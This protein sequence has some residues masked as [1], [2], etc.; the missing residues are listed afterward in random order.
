MFLELYDLAKEINRTLKFG[1]CEFI[2][3]LHENS[4]I[5]VQ[6]LH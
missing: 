3:S 6:I 4:R 2:F 5:L 1:M